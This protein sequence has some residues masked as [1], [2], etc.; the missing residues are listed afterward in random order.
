MLSSPALDLKF[1]LGKLVFHLVRNN[2]SDVGS[3]SEGLKRLISFF[4]GVSSW[5]GKL[6][7]RGI[8][9]YLSL[10]YISLVPSLSSYKGSFAT[11][12][13]ISGL[14]ADASVKV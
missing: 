10:A 5:S 8:G 7:N 13:A 9:R 11:A 6:I 2:Y 1:I 12:R 14:A 4:S 3:R